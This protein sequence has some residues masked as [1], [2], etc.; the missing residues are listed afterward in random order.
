MF[1][2]K[3]Y[4]MIPLIYKNESMKLVTFGDPR[5]QLKHIDVHNDIP[6]MIDFYIL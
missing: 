5:F 2:R 4:G 3:H 6:K 1:I